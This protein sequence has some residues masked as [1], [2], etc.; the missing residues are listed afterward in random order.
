MRLCPWGQRLLEGDGSAGGLELLLGSV[1]VVGLG[2]LEDGG[3]DV[4]DEVLGLLQAQA[5]ELLD[6]L[7]DLELV[8][9]EAL[10]DDVEVVLGLSG[11]LAA[12]GGG[13]SDGDGAAAETPKT[14]SSS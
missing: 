10:E 1:G 12:S 14:S 3:G 11:S 2:T 8:V 5:R 7:D 4:L 6:G 13:S 9:A